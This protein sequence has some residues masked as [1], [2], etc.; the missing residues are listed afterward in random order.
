MVTRAPQIG[1]HLATLNLFR[2]PDGTYAITVHEAA[3]AIDDMTPKERDD[4]R[5]H[6]YVEGKIL[7]AAN[8]I[9]RRRTGEFCHHCG[10]PE[11][12]KTFASPGSCPAC[13]APNYG[14]PDDR[15][16]K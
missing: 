9:R 14:G 1:K 8:G 13:G 4:M 15:R 2:E 11:S 3:G 16:R 7:L 12:E 5:P 6:D 10:A